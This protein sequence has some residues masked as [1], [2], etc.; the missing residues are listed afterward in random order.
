MVA[1]RPLALALLA[2]SVVTAQLSNYNC[3][4]NACKPPACRCASLAPPVANP[5][6][7]LLLTFDDAV[8]EATWQQAQSLLNRKNPNGCTV[9]STW[10]T[11]VNFSDPFLVTQWYAQGNEVADHTITHTP[12]FTGTYA[13][14]E[15][16]RKWV[17]ELAGIPLGKITGFRFPFLNYTKDALEML[18]KMGFEYETSMSAFDSDA[19]W[20]YT[21]DYGTVNDC[22]GII[23]L[24]G[25]TMQTKGLWEIPM[26]GFVGSDGKQ[27]LMDPFNDPLP[28]APS[29]TPEQLTNDYKATFDKHYNGQKAPFGVYVHPIWLGKGVPPSVP[30]G[31]AKLAA[32]AAFLDYALSRPDTW[33]VTGAQLIQYM[34]NPVPASQLGA[35]PYMSCTPNPAPPTGICN[36]LGGNGTGNA[37]PE[38]CNPPEGPFRT[39]YGCPSAYPSLANPSPQ[40]TST[41]CRLPTTCDTLWWDPVGCKCLCTSDACKWN[42]SARPINLDPASL[43]AVNKTGGGSGSANSNTKGNGAGS[44]QAGIVT[45]AAGVV[46]TILSVL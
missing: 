27:H 21:L 38:A 5:P 2:S 42:D 41:R 14:V 6:Q 36:G 11:Q 35:Q 26:Y 22:L 39:C 4:P 7:F 40:S 45:L 33:M 23:N 34:K 15:G 10:Y 44:L 3:D 18:T 46:A 28:T 1:M 8:Q 12:P 25:Q 20:P 29:L 17:N 24:C 43:N 37:A 16:M 9:K 13:E 19:V 32:I 30:D 31:T